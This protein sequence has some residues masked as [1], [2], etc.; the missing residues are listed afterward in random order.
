MQT[1]TLLGTK[2]K[3][4]VE[5]SYDTFGCIRGAERKLLPLRPVLSNYSRLVEGFRALV[6]DPVQGTYVQ[7][8]VECASAVQWADNLLQK[9]S[10]HK[11]NLGAILDQC[12][13][14]ANLLRD[15]LGAK[16][17]SAVQRQSRYSLEL[18]QLTVDDSATVRVIT[19]ITMAYLS[20]TVAAVSAC[21]QDRCCGL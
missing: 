4:S 13:F 1:R 9:L 5:L 21:C 7:N 19:V 11:E 14:A 3:H 6:E 20:F 8:V 15:R 2:L 16:D 17:Q 18:T 12:D 10:G